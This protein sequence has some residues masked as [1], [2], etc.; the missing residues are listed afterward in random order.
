MSLKYEG[1][2]WVKFLIIVEKIYFKQMYDNIVDN[3]TKD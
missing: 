1:K 3:I 2:I